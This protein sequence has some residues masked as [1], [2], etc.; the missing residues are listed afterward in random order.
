MKP[1]LIKHLRDHSATGTWT[2]SV[3]DGVPVIKISGELVSAEPFLAKLGIKLTKTNKYTERL[4]HAGMGE[5]QSGGHT[6]DVGNGVSQ[7]QE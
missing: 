7:E 5:S 4:E 6:S 2:G 3:K 1:T